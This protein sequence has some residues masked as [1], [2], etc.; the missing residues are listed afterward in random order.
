MFILSLTRNAPLELQRNKKKIHFLNFVLNSNYT[1]HTL[2]ILI[3][4]E[5][6]AGD[7]NSLTKFLILHLLNK[8]SH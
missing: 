4:G 1:I 3:A 6:L 7:K 8:E 5:Q 2:V